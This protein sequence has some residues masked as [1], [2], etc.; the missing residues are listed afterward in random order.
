MTVKQTTDRPGFENMQK[1]FYFMLLYSKYYENL[2]KMSEQMSKSGFFLPIACWSRFGALEQNQ[3]NPD[4]IGMVGQSEN[5]VKC[6][7]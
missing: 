1:I 4:E 3:D 2:T 7:Q 6:K 5:V